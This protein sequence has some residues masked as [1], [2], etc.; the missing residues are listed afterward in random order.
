MMRAVFSRIRRG[1][2]WSTRPMRCARRLES[3]PAQAHEG[4]CL[5]GRF[6]APE[7]LDIGAGDEALLCRADDEAFRIGPADLVEGGPQLLQRL[8]G[9]RVRRLSLLV[10]GQPG[11]AVAIGLPMPMLRKRR[12]IHVLSP[13]SASTSIAPPRPPPMQIDAMPRFEPVRLSVFN[14]CKTILAPEAPTGWPRAMAPPSTFSRSMS[15]SP[16]AASRPSSS[17][18]YLSSFQ[19]ARQPSTCAAKASLI[20]Q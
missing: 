5:G 12:A 19:A 4:H 18:Q 13:Y 14:R 1:T 6:E 7:L 20:S 16:M 3:V 15:S 11:Q 2:A 9:E 10:E 8:A 17:R